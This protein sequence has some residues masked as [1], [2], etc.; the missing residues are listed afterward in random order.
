MIQTNIKSTAADLLPAVIETVSE[1]AA[2]LRA[3]FHRPGG[4]RGSGSKAEIDTEIECFLK[5]RLLRLHDCSF[6]GEET[7]DVVS[8][9]VD[10]WVVDPQDGTRDFLG[11]RRGS[12]ISVALLRKGQPVLGVVFAPLAPDDNGDLI[13]WAD[14]AELARNGQ[15]V[16]RSKSDEKLVVAMNANVSDH[17]RHNQQ[18][19]PNVRIVGV[20]SPAYR[21]ALAAVGEVDAALSIVAGLDHWDVAGGHALL[22][23]AGCVLVENSGRPIEYCRRSFDG[24]IGGDAV[25][26]S[27]LVAMGPRYGPREAL[28]RLRRVS[29]VSDAGRLSRAQGCLLGQ[30]SGDALGSAVEFRSAA[31]IAKSHP[32]G[33]TRLV[34][35]GTWNLIAGQPTDDSEMALALARSLV[36]ARRFDSELVGQAYVRWERSGP[37][38][39]GS[40]TRAGISAVA[41]GRKVGRSRSQA[42]GALMRVSPLGIFAAGDPKIAADLATQEAR[43]THPHPV[44]LAAS[45]AYA[46]AIAIG[47]EGGNAKE[48][49][50]AADRFAGDGS[51]GDAIRKT[52]ASARR[53]EPDDF[54]RQMGWVLIAFQNA[55]F[56][57]M[58]GTPL[59]EALPA[60]VANGGDTDTNA[61]I[62][63]ALLGALQGRNAVPLQWR[64]AVLSCR[65]LNMGDT[66][67]P[68]P[69]EYWPDDAM[70]L[71]EALLTARKG[72]RRTASNQA[73]SMEETMSDLEALSDKQKFLLVVKLDGYV[74]A[75]VSAARAQNIG[76]SEALSLTTTAVLREFAAHG[77]PREKL[78]EIWTKAMQP[79][80]SPSELKK[81]HH[82]H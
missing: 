17:A 80:Y 41:A 66:N 51:G 14:G 20:P 53:N 8:P 65:P 78:I 48:M 64:N 15:P 82:L 77:V 68:R 74:E 22:V 62:C 31:E 2:M 34:D 72:G 73:T 32:I 52:L 36:R 4:P 27:K 59:A 13:S 29:R 67:H 46:A 71:A 76:M 58:R 35:G 6:V 47:V 54:E 28:K 40:T 18:T 60:T 50:A 55:F 25:A 16:R 33:V 3:E 49:W 7:D 61:A 39:I 79:I 19:L 11:R 70:D 69:P 44:C 5:K 38:D 63:G 37:F 57:L 26:V 9:T 24:C 75:A 21:L 56:H 23:G 12:A 43:L 30:L 81:L 42:N 10:S 45:A 1:A